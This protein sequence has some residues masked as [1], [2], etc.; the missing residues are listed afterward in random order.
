MLLAGVVGTIVAIADRQNV[1]SKHLAALQVGWGLNLV[2]GAAIVATLCGLRMSFGLIESRD[3]VTIG[4]GEPPSAASA[5]PPQST[6]TRTI[7]ERLGEL[8]DLREKGL[9]T[10]DEYDAKR[11]TLLAD[12]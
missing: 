4:G 8:A 3:T 1:T 11:A 2:L 6:V 10:E 5:S 9:I 12:V 7:A